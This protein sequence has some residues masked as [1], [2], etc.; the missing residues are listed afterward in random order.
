MDYPKS[1]PGVGLVNGRF[2]DENT[3]TGTPG[4]LIPAVWGN[5]LTDEIINVISASG[6]S[7]DESRHDQLLAAILALIDWYRLKNKPTTL[8]GYGITDALS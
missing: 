8:G 5:A 2:V 4:S 6:G 3:V 7:P 1:I